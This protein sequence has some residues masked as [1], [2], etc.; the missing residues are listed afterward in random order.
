M[1]NFNIKHKVTSTKRRDVDPEREF[2]V[3]SLV[4]AVNTLEV[5]EVRFDMPSTVAE[6]AETPSSTSAA[7]IA[8]IMSD[9]PA[10]AIEAKAEAASAA[11]AVAI[12]ACT[13]TTPCARRAPARRR[14]NPTISE[15]STSLASTVPAAVAAMARRVAT[16]ERGSAT[17]DGGSATIKVMPTV[18]K[19]LAV[20]AESCAVVDVEVEVKIAVARASP[21]TI[22]GDVGGTHGSPEAVKAWTE[23]HTAD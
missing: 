10:A 20:L 18:T 13:S 16:A 21:A 8:V 17:N 19:C 6:S 5:L 9:V 23:E 1:L 4:L 15:T 11:S 22:A 12:E 3:N 7:V 2:I 14:L